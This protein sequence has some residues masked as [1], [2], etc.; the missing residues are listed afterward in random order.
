M[1]KTIDPTQETLTRVRFAYTLVA[2]R[3]QRVKAVLDELAET[4]LWLNYTSAREA[5]LSEGW[6]WVSHNYPN[7]GDYAKV[8][9]EQNLP[10]RLG[11]VAYMR[12]IRVLKLKPFAMD[13]HAIPEELGLKAFGHLGQPT[14]LEMIRN[15]VVPPF[16][17]G[18]ES[19]CD[20]EMTILKKAIHRRTLELVNALRDIESSVKHLLSLREMGMQR[21]VPVA[22]VEESR[23]VDATLYRLLGEATLGFMPETAGFLSYHAES[24]N[25]LKA[26]PQTVFELQNSEA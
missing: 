3:A 21:S 17:D 10:D 11:E 20:W 25:K 2:H 6:S 9:Q 26:V 8:M 4:E 13:N 16:R 23:G 24:V 5:I 18:E 12:G 15:V 22:M 14:N 7:K 1:V 19:L